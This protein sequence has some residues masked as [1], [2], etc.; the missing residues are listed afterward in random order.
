MVVSLLGVWICGGCFH[1][2][3]CAVACAL[4]AGLR[5]GEMILMMKTMMM[6]VWT[7]DHDRGAV[8]VVVAIAVCAF[9]GHAYVGS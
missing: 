3:F 1:F 6:M 9:A 4:L 7:L 5:D 8:M 2:S